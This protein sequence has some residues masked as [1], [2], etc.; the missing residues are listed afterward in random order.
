MG[1]RG[2]GGGWGCRVGVGT[3]GG[4]GGWGMGVQGGGW[5][6]GVG[7][8]LW[9]TGR[10]E[11]HLLFLDGM[12]SAYSTAGGRVASGKT[13]LLNLRPRAVEVE[14][15]EPNALFCSILTTLLEVID[16]ERKNHKSQ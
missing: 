13:P 7:V 14:F 5:G 1:D 4:G 16:E 15:T 8:G 11:A 12:V 9:G 2:R 10:K 6:V 3:G